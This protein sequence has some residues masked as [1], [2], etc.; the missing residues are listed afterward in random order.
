[1][2][3]FQIRLF[4]RFDG[5]YGVVDENGNWSGM[6]SNLHNG[7]ADIGVAEFTYCCRR[8]EVVDYL[9]TIDHPTDVFAIKSKYSKLKHTQNSACIELKIM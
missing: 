3:N 6:V 8:T 2:L 1:M 4:K 9:W 7:E 5:G